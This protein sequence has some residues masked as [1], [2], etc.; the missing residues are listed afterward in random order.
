MVLLE[1]SI[2]FL[3]G[4]FQDALNTTYVRSIAERARGRATV[5]SG[6]LT[7][8]SF[9]VFARIIA[10]MGAE[11]ETAGTSIVAYALGN[12]AGTWVGMRRPTAAA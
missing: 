11:L 4:L 10:L 6:L 1:L 7:V 9:V 5:L 3:A 8:L 2:L 12:S